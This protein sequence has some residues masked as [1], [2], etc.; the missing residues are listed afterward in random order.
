MRLLLDTSALI[1]WMHR[2]RRLSAKL[3][4]TLESGQHTL[5]VSSCSA[6]EI[7]TKVRLGKLKFLPDF[8]A[9][10]DSNIRNLNVEPLAM[11]SLHSVTGA[12]LPSRH[13][14]PFDRMLAGTAIV[15]R[16]KVVTSD[17]AFKLL[18]VDTLW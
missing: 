6:W 14:D 1:M 7:A 15:E 4:R 8:L 3:R 18:G 11:S 13:G 12:Q 16:L 5:F 10:F 9:D 17:P 2:D